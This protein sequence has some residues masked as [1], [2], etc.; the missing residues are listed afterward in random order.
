MGGGGVVLT[1]M[2][3]LL[4]LLRAL[5]YHFTVT[6]FD[7]RKQGIVDEV[8]AIS[9]AFLRADLGSIDAGTCGHR[10]SQSVM[11]TTVVPLV[12]PRLRQERIDASF[13]LVLA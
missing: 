1:S 10:S 2:F 7:G 9:T 11:I 8:N 12:V 5:T 4:G 6:R 13:S 3:A